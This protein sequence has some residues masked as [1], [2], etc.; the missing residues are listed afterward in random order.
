M[1][2]PDT[3]EQKIWIQDYFD[4]VMNRR[5]LRIA[6]LNYRLRRTNT[7]KREIA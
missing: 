6:N 2:V 7:T 3:E 4:Y 5:E 1:N